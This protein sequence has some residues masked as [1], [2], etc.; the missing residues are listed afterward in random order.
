MMQELMWLKRAVYMLKQIS[1]E[2]N[3]ENDNVNVSGVQISQEVA[4]R[5]QEYSEERLR[6]YA[7]CKSQTEIF[8]GKKV[9]LQIYL[10]R[11]DHQSSKVDN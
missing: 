10:G 4:S 1:D 5:R 2:S 6:T 9:I 8:S 3:N 7:V 11:R